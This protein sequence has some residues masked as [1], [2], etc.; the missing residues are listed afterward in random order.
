MVYIDTVLKLMQGT[1]LAIPTR[2]PTRFLP[3]FQHF[4]AF[5]APIGP[6]INI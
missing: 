3:R 1:H 6:A 5:A 4:Q 2:F